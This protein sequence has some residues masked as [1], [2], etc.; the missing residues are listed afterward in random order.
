MGRQSS[1]S[2]AARTLHHERV[3]TQLI[4]H[5]GERTMPRRDD[6]LR[7]NHSQHPPEVGNALDGPDLGVDVDLERDAEP[8]SHGDLSHGPRPA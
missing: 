1:G 8:V 2:R 4:V 5:G 3:V 6:G 7:W